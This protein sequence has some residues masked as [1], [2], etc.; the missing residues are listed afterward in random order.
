[1]K[2][3]GW[4]LKEIGRVFIAVLSLWVIEGMRWV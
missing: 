1:M 4:K 2:E 3:P